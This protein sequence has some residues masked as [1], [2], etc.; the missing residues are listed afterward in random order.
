MANSIEEKY[1]NFEYKG[2]GYRFAFDPQ[3]DDPEEGPTLTS[4]C[5]S[6][7]KSLA[8][9]KFADDEAWEIASK[10]LGLNA[11]PQEPEI[12]GAVIR[13]NGMTYTTFSAR[14]GIYLHGGHGRRADG[15]RR[16]PFASMEEAAEYVKKSPY[17]YQKALNPIAKGVNYV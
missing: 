5:D 3:T 12:D 15:N 16:G 1:V 14:D 6:N 17:Y 11:S 8:P 2:L 7:G 9:S 4:V 13:F 10:K